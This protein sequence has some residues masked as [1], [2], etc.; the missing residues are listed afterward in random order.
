[1]RKTPAPVSAITAGNLI[2]TKDDVIS[3]DALWDSSE[4]CR[5]SVS[6]KQSV[7][8]FELNKT[9]RIVRLHRELRDGVY[10]SSRPRTIPIYYPKRRDAVSIPYKDRVYQRSINDLVLYPEMTRHFIIDNCACQK[11]KG[12]QFC[13]KRIRQHL[14][15]H[16]CNHG[17]DGWVVQIDIHGYYPNMSHEAVR[18][19]FARY[20]TPEIL[21]MVDE[22]LKSQETGGGYNPGS[23]MIQ[24]AGIA[25]LDP[26]DHYIKEQLHVKYYVRYMDDFLMILPTRERA[27]RVLNAVKTYLAELGFETNPNKTHVRTLSAG[28]DMIGFKFRLSKTGR[29]SQY[30]LQQNVRH[31][32]N[33]LIRMSRKGVPREDA[34]IS[35]GC[36][37]AHASEGNNRR[38]IKNMHTLFEELYPQHNKEANDAETHSKNITTQGR[39]GAAGT[40]AEPVHAG[41]QDRI[42]SDDERCRPGR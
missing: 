3:M 24:I 39:E 26:L 21:E 11:G 15:R 19:S 18:R 4:K 41:R 31:E 33:K 9:E 17:P 40:A 22:I 27:E 42:F 23:Q 1:M 2:M 37:E 25:L 16:Y 12:P 30:L 5:K 20:I 14:W 13:R 7:K 29:I 35:L 34:E 38:A 36:W 28:F 32:R 10:E 8:S 6:W